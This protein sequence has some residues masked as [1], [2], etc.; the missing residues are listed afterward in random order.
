LTI[1]LDA[2]GQAVNRE[3]GL[4]IYPREEFAQDRFNYEA[5]QHTLFGGPT[6]QGKS[7][8]A[9]KLLEHTATP[10]LP[11]YYMVVKPHDALVTSEGKRLGFKTTRRWPPPRSPRT[12]FEDKPPGYLIWPKMGNMDTDRDHVAEVAGSLLRE[13]YAAG[14]K[15]SPGILVCDD[16]MVMSKILHLDQ[17]MV[18]HIAMSRALG[19]GGWY[20]F[21]KPTDSGR[22]SIW[23]YGASE[24]IF[25]FRDPDKRNRQRYGEIGG[26]DPKFIDYATMQ[27]QPYQS[28]YIKRTGQRMCIVDA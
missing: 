5:G 19:L 13:R 25:L 15:G 14:I 11:A 17:E 28:L 21:Q 26:A 6:G 3:T 22:A 2:A 24:H 4:V 20:F 10:D 23:S 16:S 27:L 7:R 1:V 18:T 8:L 9:F 12:Y